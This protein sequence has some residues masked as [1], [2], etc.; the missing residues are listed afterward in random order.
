[1]NL[2]HGVRPGR[3]KLTPVASRAST[4]RSARDGATA[5]V[6]CLFKVNTPAMLTLG[7]FWN[8]LLEL[9]VTAFQR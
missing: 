9:C 4:A 3:R 1:M 8:P 2:G 7:V 5:H 6:E